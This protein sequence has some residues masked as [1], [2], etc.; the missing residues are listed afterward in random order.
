MVNMPSQGNDEISS[1]VRDW[2]HYQSTELADF[3]GC[4][5]PLVELFNDYF[6]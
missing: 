6:S 4:Y 2:A 3:P 1:L 5:P